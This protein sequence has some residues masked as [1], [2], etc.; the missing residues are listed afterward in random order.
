MAASS[1]RND[2][3]SPFDEGWQSPPPPLGAL[4]LTDTASQPRRPRGKRERD[5]L[6]LPPVSNGE[7]SD[8]ERLGRAEPVVRYD[9]D[10]DP[11]RGELYYLRAFT[12]V[13][14]SVAAVLF[15]WMVLSWS[16]LL[17]SLSDR[18]PNDFPS[19]PPTPPGIST[20]PATPRSTP[21][22]A[23]PVEPPVATREDAGVAVDVIRYEVSGT[24]VA[25][26]GNITYLADENYS[27][28]Q[29]TDASLPW[30]TEIELPNGSMTHQPLSLSAQSA[31]QDDGDITC[32]ILRNGEL[33]TEST[34]SGPFA[35]VTCSG[36]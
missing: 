18:S 33:I 1:G 17:T 28:Q 10:A 13:V 15:I 4:D 36:S 23:A 24:G 7:Y 32:R 26:A 3:N 16:A 27:Q 30:A 22:P 12:Y 29:A 31:S 35:V 21:A 8:R 2:C 5:Y 11:P 20:P 25:A 14:T 34:S 6:V 19:T 9:A